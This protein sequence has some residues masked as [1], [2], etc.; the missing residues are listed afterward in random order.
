[1]K[2]ALLLL[3]FAFGSHAAFAQDAE[4]DI[5]NLRFG[6]VATPMMT[7]Y[8]PEGK[9]LESNGATAKMGGGLDVEIRLNNVASLSTGFMINFYG[10]K[11]NMLDTAYYFLS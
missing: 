4:N 2:K 9:N 5:K 3:T 1:M 10:G 8:K 7:W 6:L 11:L